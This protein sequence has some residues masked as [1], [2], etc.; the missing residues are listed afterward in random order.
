MLLE[1]VLAL[2][3]FVAAA[4]AVLVGLGSS[5]G[6][7][8]RLRHETHAADLAVTTMSLIQ[9]DLLPAVSLPEEP[10]EDMREDGWTRE[11]EVTPADAGIETAIAAPPDPT[12][13]RP[14]SLQRIEVVVRHVPSGVVRRLTQLVRV[15]S[16]ERVERPEPQVDPARLELVR[17]IFAEEI[18]ERERRRREA[19]R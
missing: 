9:M 2:G 15:N 8:E 19:G 13:H 5:I 17:K 4:T 1:V 12:R 6:G 10:I 18:G 7:V 11:I 16:T 3:L 14:M